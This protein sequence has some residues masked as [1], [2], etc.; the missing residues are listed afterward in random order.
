LHGQVAQKGQR[1]AGVGSRHRFTI[2]FYPHGSQETQA[3]RRLH[4]LSENLRV[5]KEFWAIVF[6]SGRKVWVGVVSN[7]HVVPTN[8]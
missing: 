3:K 4:L 7:V 8:T 2:L 5:I 6:T 1:L